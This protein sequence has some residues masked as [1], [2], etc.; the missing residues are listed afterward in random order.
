MKIINQS[1]L[2]VLSILFWGQIYAQREV[3]IVIGYPDHP[4]YFIYS[5][6]PSDEHARF[7]GEYYFSVTNTGNEE[8]T[9]WEL[10][11]TWKTLNSTWGVVNK[12]ILNATTGEIKLTGPSWDQTLSVGESIVLNGEWISSGSVEDWIDFLPREITM[13][14][15]GGEVNVVYDTQGTIQG[16]SYVIQKVKPIENERKTFTN[17]K[18]VAYFP[19]FDAQNA[20]CSLQKYGSNIDQLRVQLYSIST[21]GELRAGQDLPS[22]VDP[23][24]EIDFWYDSLVNMGVVNYCNQNNIELIPVV[25]NYNSDLGD[26]EQV[27]VHNM[28]MNPIKRTQ[29]LQDLE[30]LLITHPNFAGIDIDYESLQAS[31]RDNY[32]LFMEDLADIIHA[33]NK[34]LTTAVHTKVGHGTWY[35]PQAQD[36][37]RIGNA[38]DEILLM[39]Y[40]LHWATSPTYSNPPPTAGCQST[41]DWMND[42]ASFAISEI[43][44]PSKIQ[45]GI[46]FYGYR[47]KQGFENHT[48]NDPGIGLTNEDAT[49]LMQD[50]GLTYNDVQ[51]DANGMDPYFNI[52]INGENW[53]CY[54]QDSLSIH[55]KLTSLL[56]HDLKDYVGGVGIW[57]LGGETDDMWKALVYQLQDDFADVSSIECSNENSM[58][59]L[60]ENK[61]NDIV[62]YPNPTESNLYVEFINEFNGSAKIIDLLGN[63]LISKPVKSNHF[64]IELFELK[65]G[66][67]ILE[68]SDETNVHIVKV[69]KF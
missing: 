59:T 67:Y 63:C 29:H 42:V 64:I 9:N 26:F 35:G 50:N 14:A 56:E 55:H 4:D 15:D 18:I 30:N 66:S 22:G 7:G 2:V 40:D 31:D 60:Y 25:Y 37:E 44:D 49:L 65:S 27:G 48:L 53:V 36:L 1:I 16:M 58:V 62:V 54:F 52:S 20:W 57:R 8:L 13:N 23:Y 68:I 11:T 39:T 45:L 12:T 10:F 46:P 28:M 51:R 24:S 21:E 32:S 19:I 41:T 6:P 47:W 3:T 69:I 43:D 17:K 34:L 38:V 33:E 61:K 5:I